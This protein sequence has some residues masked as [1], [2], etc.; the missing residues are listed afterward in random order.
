[1]WRGDDC[2]DADAWVKS[3]LKAFAAVVATFLFLC[4]L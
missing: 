4:L 1:M 3:W 2:G